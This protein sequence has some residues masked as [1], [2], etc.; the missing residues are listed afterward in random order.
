MSQA[1]V[2]RYKEQKANRK[3][4]MQKEKRER[5]LW[6]VGGSLV[7]VALVAWIG[8]SAFD[9]LYEP[10]RRFYVADT[11]AVSDYLSGLS[12]ADAVDEV[13]DAVDDEFAEEEDVT[14]AET[15]AEDVTE[16]ETDAAEDA[17]E[18]ETDAAEETTEAETAASEKTTEAGTDAAEKTTEKTTEK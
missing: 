13:V 9:K 5:M 4:I 14:E 16:A 17:T 15:A 11:A 6:K 1:K 8:Y 7:A 12:S 10:P 18:A 3:K 2:D